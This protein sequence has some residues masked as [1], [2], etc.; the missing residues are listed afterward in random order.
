MVLPGDLPSLHID[1]PKMQV[2]GVPHRKS[3]LKT[4]S[5]IT[6]HLLGYGNYLL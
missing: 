4:L 6:V 3:A 1:Q 2:A 5:L